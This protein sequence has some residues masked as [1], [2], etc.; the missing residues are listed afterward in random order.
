[1]TG[2]VYLIGAGP[3]DPELITRRAARRLAEADLVLYDALVHP[4]L[5]ELCAVGAEKVHVGK[6]A[7]R[8]SERQ[9]A[10]H[11]K[12]I[13]AARNGRTVARL[14]G[15]DPYLFGRGSEEAEALSAAGIRFEIVPGV[16]SPIA[17]T[18]YAGMSLTHRHASS[19]V[20]YI[21][22]TESVEK[23]RSSH[24][25]A[26]LATATET[27]VIFMGVR[28]LGS[29]MDLLIEHG[30]SPQAPAAVIE[31]ASLP[32]QKTIVGTVA[33]IATLAAE[34]GVGMPA[35]TV[36]GEIVRLRQALR[37]YDNQPLFGRRVLVT[38]PEERARTLSNRLRDE[39]A[40][41][42]CLPAIRLDTSGE[43][44]A[45]EGAVDLAGSY[46]WVV[47]TSATGV[48]AFFDAAARQGRDARVVGRARL[49]AVGPS[50]A[51]ALAR[52]GLRADLVPAQFRGEGVASALLDAHGPD[53]R[54]LRFL[55]PRAEVARE[56]LPE[57]LRGA[58]ATVD[59]VHAYRN[60]PAT[61]DQGEV[62]RQV[63]VRREVDIVTF[64]APSTAHAVAGF[65]GPGAAALLAPLT[66]A[67]IGPATTA[68]AEGLGIRVDVTARDSTA[69]GLVDALR[70]H[71]SRDR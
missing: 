36:V 6:R 26:K 55:L 66:V 59:V 10:I 51:T 33:T 53:L 45:L 65:L 56:V 12:M 28:K 49:C 4:D 24:D 62:I 50:T 35:L 32:R 18:A 3:G 64:S 25:W 11:E 38:R 20:A 67:S 46:D 69:D 58:G 40:E 27:L 23:D 19:S 2:R 31:S 71:A 8:V 17:A 30:R 43:Q 60:L 70:A 16:P 7:G 22:A 57:T 63:I 54:G 52:R 14:K 5:L 34:A 29:M 39:G 47:F 41:S 1:M 13:S 44:A 42:V 61:P 48:D 9:G 37:W 15:G 21:T 68:A